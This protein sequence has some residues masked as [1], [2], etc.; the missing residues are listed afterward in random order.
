MAVSQS[1]LF[2]GLTV[3]TCVKD[4]GIAPT[5][6]FSYMCSLRHQGSHEHFCGGMLI[7][8]DWILTAAQCIDRGEDSAPVRPIAYC[9]IDRLNQTDPDLVI[10]YHLN[11]FGEVVPFCRFLMS[12]LL[13]YMSA[14]AEMRFMVLTSL[15]SNWRETPAW[16]WKIFLN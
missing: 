12:V 4:G 16:L 10:S 13:I 11:A 1:V 9:G 8:P 6:R 3:T 14:G 5:G 15:C 2:E 7:R